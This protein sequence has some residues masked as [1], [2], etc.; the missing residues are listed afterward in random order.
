ML[1]IKGQKEIEKIMNMKEKTDKIIKTNIE[2]NPKISYEQKL[3]LFRKSFIKIL[4]EE[5]EEIKTKELKLQK[6][7]NIL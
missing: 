3:D 1:R 6:E 5:K 7:N 2:K 4:D